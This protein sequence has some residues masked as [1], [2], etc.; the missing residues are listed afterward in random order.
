[1]TKKGSKAQALPEEEPLEVATASDLA[2]D[3][4]TGFDEFY[5]VTSHGIYPIA[6]Q[7]ITPETEFIAVPHELRGEIYSLIDQTMGIANPKK[8]KFRKTLIAPYIANE[9]RGGTFA[10]IVMMLFSVV[11][12]A[13]FPTMLHSVGSDMGA[14]LSSALVFSIPVF[15]MGA[16]LMSA[17]IS[18]IAG[19]RIARRLI[20]GRKKLDKTLDEVSIE[21]MSLDSFTA[22]DGR[23]FTV[24]HP[25][26]EQLKEAKSVL[27]KRLEGPQA[28][29]EK[30][31][32]EIKSLLEGEFHEN[33][34]ENLLALRRKKQE[35]TE[36][37]HAL[38]VEIA[39][40]LANDTLTV[41]KA[42]ENA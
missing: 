37:A 35:L 38:D 9:G 31:N 22:S 18:G 28:E 6:F 14:S 25:S 15:A 16:M 24:N 4:K 3:T 40:L 27:N 21:V 11:I 41:D 33:D 20:K 34:D 13:V 5:E 1:M 30:I 36:E 26:A 42:P 12:A 2:E 19:N 8:K 10:A 23:R 32:G 39:S 7:D 17:G 29:I